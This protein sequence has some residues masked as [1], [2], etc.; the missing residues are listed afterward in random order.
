MGQEIQ[1]TEHSMTEVDT[2]FFLGLYPLSNFLKKDIVLASGCV[3][4]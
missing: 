3:P 4:I 1:K 2:T